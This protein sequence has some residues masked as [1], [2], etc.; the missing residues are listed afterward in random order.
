MS[1]KSARQWPGVCAYKMFA[2]T[3]YAGA[4]VRDGVMQ[5]IDQ[6][7]S[8]RVIV[9]QGPAGHGKSTAL[10]QLKDR[11][12]L[13]GQ[14][15]GWLTLDA[16]DND[17]ER[18]FLHFLAL[19]SSV[20]ES[21]NDDAERAVSE[22]SDLNH[23]Y[24]SDW[25]LDRL[26]A[27][28]RPMSLF[29][30]EFQTV[31]DKGVLAFFKDLFERAPA[32]L[33]IYI[34]SRSLPDVGFARLIVNNRAMILRGDD[35]RFTPQEVERFFATS[36]DLGIDS[37]EMD[38]IY[39]RTEGWPAALQL[40]R[41]T[42]SNPLVRQSLGDSNACAPRE[43]AEYLAEN[44][45]AMQSAKIQ[46]FLLRT[47][48]LTRLCAPLCDAVLG[49]QDSGAIL[50]QLE[51]SGM[52]L[53]M[54]D[55]NVGWFKYHTLFSSILADQLRSQSTE[56]A[57][58][59][60]RK[61][62]LWHM[63]NQLY[64]EAAHHAIACEDFTLAA[65]SL[66]LWFSTLV[67]SAHLMT[68]ERWYESLPFDQVSRRIDLA[69]K[70]AYALIFLRRRTLAK[71]LLDLLEPLLNTGSVC[72]TT[73]PNVVLSM[74]AISRDDIPSA[75]AISENVAFKN[76][77]ASGF[78]AFELGAVAN[79]RS[80]CALVSQDFE[81]A[82][83]CL[84]IATGYNASVDAPFSSGYTRAVNGV[85]LLLQ[86][87][88]QSAL[89][90]F[91]AGVA[92]QG[93]G[94]G[95]SFA[96]AALASCYVWALYEANE[97]AAAEAVFS[98]HHDIISE[99]TLPDFLTVAYISMCR[100]HDANA[101]LT[102]AEGILDE[103]A[104]IGHANGWSRL[105]GIVNSERI[106]RSLKAGS[107]DR[108]RT[109]AAKNSSAGPVLPAGWIP[110]ANDIEDPSFGEIRLALAELDLNVAARLLDVEFKR[111]TGRVLRQIRLYLLRAQ[112]ARAR[113]DR[114]SARRCIRHA[115]KLAQSGGFIR[116]FL[117]DSRQILN[118]LREEFQPEHEGR[119]V[120]EHLEPEH[121]FVEAILNASGT[122]LGFGLTVAHGE[123]QPLTDRER[124]MLILLA[125]GI[126]NKD[127]ARRLFVS[128]NTVKFHLKNIYAKLS[129]NSRGQ[130]TTAARRIGLIQ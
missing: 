119:R 106:R 60:H 77:Q 9:L 111:Q 80:Y 37:E 87:R 72:N 11:C 23:R 71:P 89:E 2:P 1:T 18:F 39:Y 36:S 16:G 116:C 10:Q 75:V 61:A 4:I 126:S 46:T 65:E 56:L 45:L 25:I 94:P 31:T 43:L 84:T 118:L 35:L 128:A 127:I 50:Q 108:A 97:L 90:C 58:A 40:F 27:P 107:I 42:L 20:Q 95:K 32:Q 122:D 34:G 33:R 26:S 92:E 38:T 112:C 130:A 103:A 69:I 76:Q 44:V 96:S 74:A 8:A 5:R 66:N 54:L 88:L 70:C 12:A 79:L 47:S 19:V 117:D 91:R 30:D 81:S 93:V 55:P 13:A 14:L 28:N 49:W 104:A 99:S 21:A 29:I 17:P 57:A 85:S 63:D 52:F 22:S 123:L 64:E 24:R 73:S 3:A 62:A 115:V 53:R 41:L 101:R 109:V 100:I 110:F 98:Q 68:A 15:T 59:V 113:E 114:T 78:A 129:V 6:H 120:F 48:V 82:R 83:E 7:P 124:E 51:R 125:N 102:A 67:A 121:V 86:G 105:I